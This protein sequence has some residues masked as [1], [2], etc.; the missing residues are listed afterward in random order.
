MT[1]TGVWGA[2]RFR[3][4]AIS[5][6]SNCAAIPN[7]PVVTQDEPRPTAS[8]N[9]HRVLPFMRHGFRLSTVFLLDHPGALAE[10]S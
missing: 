10:E 3:R 4:A 5:G 2:F 8:R 6:I 1:L 9:H 7:A